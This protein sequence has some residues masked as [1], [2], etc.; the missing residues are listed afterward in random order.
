MTPV[1]KPYPRMKD[2]GVDWLGAIPEHW[3]LP[4]LGTVLRERGALNHDGAVQDVLSVVRHRGVIPYS[5]KGNI[6]NKKSEDTSRYKI[7][8]PDDIVLNSMNVIIGSV[9]LSRYKGCLSPV[10]CVLARRSDN[11][12]VRYFSS[13]FQA[14]PFHK[15]LI[16]L[17]NGILA[18]RMRIPMELLKC[19]P[20]PRPPPEEQTAIARFLDH[21]DHRIQ[22]YIRAKEKLIALL[23]EYKQAL[24]HQAV[25]GQI[26]VRTGMPYPEYRESGVEWL[27]RVPAHWEVRKL[28][29]C[30]GTIGGMTPSMDNPRFWESDDIP[31]VTPKDMKH[32]V[33]C[34]SSVKVAKAAIDE[35]SLSVIAPAAILIVVRGMIL[36]RKVPIA[37]TTAPVTINQDMKALVPNAMV[38]AE[39]LSILLNASQD[40]F[41]P[42]IDEA[43][44]GT[45]RLPTE[46]WWN[47][48]VAIPPREEQE[49]IVGHL[50]ALTD[51]LQALESSSL[52][53]CD[54][55]REYRTRL[56]ADVVT[57]KLDVREAAAGLQEPNFSMAERREA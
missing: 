44:H 13:I 23:D 16:R 56:I 19:E 57:G 49:R 2:S 31:W 47:L 6:G 32:A 33:I 8:W 3:D 10:Y 14:E 48:S 39:F 22:K 51:S 17:G 28:R 5:E 40:G 12:D 26:D 37:H 38:V 24:V 34:D 11:D 55:L 29:R 52:R 42:L 36:V 9:G 54:Q 4:R 27:G 50:K 43:G 18:H 25:T 1:F 45:R 46:R 35:T 41:K 7:V 30:G 15:G 20:F 53:A 21:M